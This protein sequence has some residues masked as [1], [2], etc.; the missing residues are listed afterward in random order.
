MLEDKIAEAIAAELRRQ[1]ADRPNDLA[2]VTSRD[3]S[4]S[5]TVTGRVDMQALAMAVAGSI[6]GGP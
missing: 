4:V 1:A 3:E 5:L 6:A 2:V